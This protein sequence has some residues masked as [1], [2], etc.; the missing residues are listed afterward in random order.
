MIRNVIA[1][2]IG[3]IAAT[4]VGMGFFLVL[5]YLLNTYGSRPEI[6]PFIL[7]LSLIHI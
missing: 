1:V 2:I 4:A 7:M 6:G 5:W 3:I